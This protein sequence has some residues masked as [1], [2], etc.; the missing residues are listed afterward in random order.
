MVVFTIYM[1]FTFAIQNILQNNGLHKIHL[2]VHPFRNPTV[3]TL[4]LYIRHTY[5][6]YVDCTLWLI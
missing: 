3:Y 4:H 6:A 2:N 1:Y 5:A